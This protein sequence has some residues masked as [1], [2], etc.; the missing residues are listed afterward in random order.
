MAKNDSDLFDRLRRAGVRRQVAKTL[1]EIGEGAGQKAVRSA[2]SAVGELRSLAEEIERRLPGVMPDAGAASNDRC[3]RERSLP[4]SN[5]AD[6]EV[7]RRERERGRP[8]AAAWCAT[9]ARGGAGA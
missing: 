7:A 5:A 1:S 4:T 6:L 9:Q 2:R 3:P 8:R